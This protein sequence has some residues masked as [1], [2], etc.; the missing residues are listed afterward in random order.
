MPSSKKVIE[1]LSEKDG[2]TESDTEDDD[3][4]SENE[5]D[6]FGGFDD[7]E[8]EFSKAETYD[9]LEGYNRFMT[10]FNDGLYI[11][12]LDPVAR[13]YRYV[14][15]KSGRRA[16]ER[17]IDNVLFPVRFSGSILQAKFDCA[18]I[19]TTRFIINTTI[20]LLGFFD[21]AKAWLNLKGCNEDIGQAIGYWD[22]GPGPHVVLPFFGPSNLRDALAMYPESYVDPISQMRPF[23]RYAG[24]TA[25]KAVNYTSL[26][27]GEYESF[28]R[29]AVDFYILVRD[30]YEQLRKNKIKE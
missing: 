4:D 30:A 7:F 15:P 20:G 29:D 21:P 13:G 28:K 23:V 1:A 18:G 25:Y 11:Y 10:D 2:L 8:E 24:A 19:E 27:I 12:L 16:V 9:P 3:E 14:L 6:D 26:H 17:F 22:V 5:E